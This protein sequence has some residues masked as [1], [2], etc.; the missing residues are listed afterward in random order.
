MI[1]I[2]KAKKILGKPNEELTD[3]QID[4]MINQC[5]ALA[6]VMFE[7]FEFTKKMEEVKNKDD[8]S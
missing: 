1:T 6:E 8:K 2:S 4:L 3:D 5:Y 7:H